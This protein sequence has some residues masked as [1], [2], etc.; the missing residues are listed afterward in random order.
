MNPIRQGRWQV[1]SLEVNSKPA[2]ENDEFRT[3][4]TTPDGIRIEPAG[5]EFTFQQVAARSAVLES[6]SQVFYADFS[7]RGDQLTLNLTRPSFQ[8]KVCLKATL[9]TAAQPLLESA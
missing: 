5:I 9:V 3:L 7:I 6:R 8:E 1:H 2:C 4:E